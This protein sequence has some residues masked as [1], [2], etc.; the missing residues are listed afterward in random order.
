[1]LSALLYYSLWEL[2]VSLG[3]ISTPKLK[4]TTPRAQSSM[5]THSKGHPPAGIF[6]SWYVAACQSTFFFRLY[7]N[8]EVEE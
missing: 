8:K 3:S 7:Y 5:G 1:M 2:A 4:D 6:N